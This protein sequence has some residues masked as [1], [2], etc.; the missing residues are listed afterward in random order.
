MNYKQ[1]YQQMHKQAGFK[2]SLT[3]FWQWLKSILNK[4][5][6]KLSNVQKPVLKTADTQ[7]LRDI[8]ESLRHAALHYSVQNGGGGKKKFPIAPRDMLESLPPI[9]QNAWDIQARRKPVNGWVW[10]LAPQSTSNNP[11]FL[12]KPGSGFTGQTFIYDVNGNKLK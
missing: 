7:Q 11:L 12:V 1:V 8:V 10:S 6:S 9:I 5:M 2:Q 3:S 4:Y